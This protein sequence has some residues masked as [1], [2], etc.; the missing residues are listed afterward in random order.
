MPLDEGTRTQRFRSE[1]MPGGPDAGRLLNFTFAAGDYFRTMGI[2]VVDGR[3]FE[4]ADH[5]SALGNVVISR[6][7]A[8]TLWPGSRPSAAA[9]SRRARPTGTAW[10]ASSRT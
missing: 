2:D 7:A 3:P 10:L 4:T 9:C 6:S 5:V 8:R 1:D